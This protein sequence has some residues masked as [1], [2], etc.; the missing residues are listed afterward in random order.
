MKKVSVI[1]PIYNVEKF[2][3]RS[4]DSII[5]QK[6]KN[7]EIIL[8]NDGSTDKCLEICREYESVDDRI[9]VI[10]KSNGGVSSARNAG[11]TICSGDYITFADPDDYLEINMYDTMVDELEKNSAEAVVCNFYR[12]IKGKKHKNDIDINKLGIKKNDETLKNIFF[13]TDFEG[14]PWNKLFLRQA[15]LDRE[16]NDFILFEEGIVAYED[17][18]YCAKVFPKVSKVV[19]IG[20]PLYNYEQN[21]NCISVRKYFSSEQIL[22]GIETYKKICDEICPLLP[23]ELSDLKYSFIN[24]IS[25]NGFYQHY[26]LTGKVDKSI[27]VK[28]K[29]YKKYGIKPLKTKIIIKLKVLVTYLSVSP[30]L[31][32]TLEQ[33]R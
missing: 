13:S 22:Q 25:G 31:I 32:N 2:L 5:S 19:F 20:E 10:D 9:I 14:F 12:I 1:I 21:D 6:Y 18:L 15:I 24:V 17:S 11:L 26:R 7:L 3:R 28:A 23:K 30:E 8:V 29:T 16:T 33:L 27:L 4:L